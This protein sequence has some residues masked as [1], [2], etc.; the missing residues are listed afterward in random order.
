MKIYRLRGKKGQ[1]LNS[2]H[3]KIE[4]VY[5]A[6]NKINNKFKRKKKNTKKSQ[7]NLSKKNYLRIEH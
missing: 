1:K 3:N 5:C 4:T 6:L 7:I 2:N